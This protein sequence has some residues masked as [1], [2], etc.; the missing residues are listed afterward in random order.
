[1]RH[2][3]RR[4]RGALL[5][6]VTWALAWGI[7]G[8]GLMELIFDRHG[9]IADIWPAVLGIPGFFGGIIFSIVLAATERHRRFDELSLP[10]F[11]AW[12]ALAGALLGVVGMAVFGAG[13]LVLIPF[14]VLGAASASGS[15]ALAR[16][17]MDRERLAAGSDAKTRD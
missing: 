7:G 14:G 9:R 17:G 16:Q 3:L 12:G 10:R 5:V 13:P 4:V 15:L 1:M 8:G 11:G 2:W 6:G